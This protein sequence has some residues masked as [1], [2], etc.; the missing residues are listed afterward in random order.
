[1]RAISNRGDTATATVPSS[2]S[3]I[4]ET[5]LV[6]TVR[7]VL[8]VDAELNGEGTHLSIEEASSSLPTEPVAFTGIFFRSE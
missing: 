1:M 6:V 3:P 5:G 2:A 7:S 4:V 8:F